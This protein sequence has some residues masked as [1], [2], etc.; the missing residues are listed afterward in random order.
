MPQS[1][2]AIAPVL[3]VVDGVPTTT[4]LAVAEHFNKLHK[5]ILKAIKNLE[6]SKE[7][8]ERNFAPMINVINIGNG[9]TRK[10]PAY[11]MTRDGFVFLCMGFT[12]KEAAAW[13]ERYITAFNE[14]EAA[15]RSQA[16]GFAPSPGKAGQQWILSFGRD[17]QPSLRPIPPNILAGIDAFLQVAQFLLDDHD[18]SQMAPP[19]TS[20]TSVIPPGIYELKKA[21]PA[22]PS[23]Q[24]IGPI[25]CVDAGIVYQLADDHII[26]HDKKLFHYIPQR[27]SYQKIIYDNGRAIATPI[28][29]S[30]KLE[31]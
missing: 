16:P 18:D 4:S 31:H 19:Q 14:M 2:T 25:L 7:F 15:L 22:D 9:A 3:A 20:E 30:S 29:T 13:K 27:G 26:K 24:Y 10:D 17:G 5:D 23:R 12:G 11:R 8:H 28:A 1:S 6:C 21:I